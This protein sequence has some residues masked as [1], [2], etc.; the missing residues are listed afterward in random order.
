M[1]MLGNIQNFIGVI[2]NH[3]NDSG[4]PLGLSAGQIDEINQILTLI[5]NLISDGIQRNDIVKL[6]TLMGEMAEIM[7]EISAEIKEIIDGLKQLAKKLFEDPDQVS[8]GSDSP[9]KMLLGMESK[10]TLESSEDPLL[11]DSQMGADSSLSQSSGDLALNQDSLGSILEDSKEDR[12]E[13][14]ENIL[15]IINDNLVLSPHNFNAL[16]KGLNVIKNKADLSDNTV[17]DYS[18]KGISDDASLY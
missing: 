7:P 2:T 17:D 3:V 18:I 8:L 5:K 13:I 6:V 4:N 12:Y 11:L 14:A 1:S 16:T 15:N 10:L 9:Q